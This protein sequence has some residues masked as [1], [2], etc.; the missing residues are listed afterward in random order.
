ML[1]PSENVPYSY[2]S[3][4]L[5]SLDDNIVIDRSIRAAT[6]ENFVVPGT[7]EDFYDYDSSF[8]VLQVGICDCSRRVFKKYEKALL[9]FMNNLPILWRVST[10]IS[11]YVREKRYLFTKLRQ[12]QNV[13]LENY[14]I[15]INKI[16]DNILKKNPNLEKIIIV[17]ILSPGPLM[18]K[19][20]Y[21]ILDNVRDYNLFLSSLPNNNNKVHILDLY[22]FT[23]DNPQYVL[24]DGHH[25]TKEVHC[26]IYSQ[27]S[28]LIKK[29]TVT[30]STSS[31]EEYV[32][33]V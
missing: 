19:K 12:I 4:Y 28:R 15:N 23:K 20:S 9:H 18:L 3:N 8:F 30:T 29:S 16:I 22:S 10:K 2:T 31:N 27:I 17:N 1:R 24:K 13:P 6:T 33:P 26:F 25:F 21:K 14:K 32:V 5:L 11:N 7:E